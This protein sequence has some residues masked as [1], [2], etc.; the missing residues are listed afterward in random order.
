MLLAQHTQWKNKRPVSNKEEGEAQHSRLSF[1][2]HV[3]TAARGLGGLKK[4]N[5]SDKYPQQN[6]RAAGQNDLCLCRD[7]VW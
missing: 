2:L 6:Q 3:C 5:R 1:D 7:G 4:K